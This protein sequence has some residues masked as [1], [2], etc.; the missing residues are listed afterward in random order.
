MKINV[1]CV[2]I[3]SKKFLKFETY[4]LKQ[5]NLEAHMLWKICTGQQAKCAKAIRMNKCL[6]LISF[7]SHGKLGVLQHKLDCHKG[8]LLL[9]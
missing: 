2:R 5:A 6:K 7:T 4:N 3:Q 1:S 9:T 8:S